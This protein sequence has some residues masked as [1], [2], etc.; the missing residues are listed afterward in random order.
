[1]HRVSREVEM[2]YFYDVDYLFLSRLRNT[3]EYEKKLK[4][5]QDVAKRG[6]FSN[7]SVFKRI[8]GFLGG[9][10]KFNLH[11]CE[12]SLTKEI[13]LGVVTTTTTEA[14]D[15]GLQKPCHRE[16]QGSEIEEEKFPAE[17]QIKNKSR[18]PAIL[19]P[20]HTSFESIPDVKD[21]K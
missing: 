5:S 17:E 13:Y 19:N 6:W 20:S 11:T 21:D 9:W 8:S 18:A 14:I 4:E 3:E 1:M 2:F 10:F 15:L 16:L 12:S 7:C